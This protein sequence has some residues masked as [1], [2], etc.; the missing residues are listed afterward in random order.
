MP[1]HRLAAGM[2]M[3]VLD[4]DLLLI[5][6]TMAVKRLDQG[7]VGASELVGVVQVLAP[8]IGVTND[9]SGSC[10]HPSQRRICP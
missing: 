1:D 9:F 2:H 6:A 5:F 4:R 7:R 10:S 3:D 8:I